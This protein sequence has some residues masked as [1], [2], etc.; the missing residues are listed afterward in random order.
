M[1]SMPMML[2]HLPY[3]SLSKYSCRNSSLFVYK[4]DVVH[5]LR[6]SARW[7]LKLSGIKLGFRFQARKADITTRTIAII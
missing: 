5:H 6:A 1:I 7:T 3:A 2:L 4:S